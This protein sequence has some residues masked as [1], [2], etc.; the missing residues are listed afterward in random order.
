[1]NVILF[2]AVLV[3]AGVPSGASAE[4]LRIESGLWEFT[5]TTPGATGGPAGERA[6]R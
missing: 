1:V 4:A 5:T 3:L 6:R 2:A